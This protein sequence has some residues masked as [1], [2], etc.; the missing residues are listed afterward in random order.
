[1][2]V[3][4]LDVIAHRYAYDRDHV[5]V[6]AA[7]ESAAAVLDIGFG[8]DRSTANSD[9]FAFQAGHAGRVAKNGAGVVSGG[10]TTGETGAHAADALLVEGKA[11]GK[12]VGR[13]KGDSETEGGFDECD[14][15]HY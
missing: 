2:L 8:D 4:W 14:F 7:A 9:L 12:Q 6:V 10:R 11:A 15:F 3:D 5:A 13:G 1:M